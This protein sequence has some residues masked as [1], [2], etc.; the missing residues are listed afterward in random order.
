M[1]R[2]SYLSLFFVSMLAV[3]SAACTTGNGSL[4]ADADAREK[5]PRPR[6]E[7]IAKIHKQYRQDIRNCFEK[8]TLQQ[9]VD[10]EVELQVPRSGTPVSIRLLESESLP[11]KLRICL[12]SVLASLEYGKAKSGATYYQVLTFDPAQKRVSFTKP[13]DAYHRWG[14]TGDEIKAV[15]EQRE[16]AIDKCYEL[17]ADSPRGRLV[18]TLAIDS[19][20]YVARAGIRNSTLGS[21]PV[22]DCLLDVAVEMEF[23]PPRGGGVVVFDLPFR[24]KPTKGW[25]R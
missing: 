9:V 1:N 19:T 23:P 10:V 4:E 13:I 22:E 15:V 5:G 6:D 8:C 11:N 17:A 3:A 18:L 20:G 25:I 12:E 7:S 16:E 24:F 14:L 21:V 2:M